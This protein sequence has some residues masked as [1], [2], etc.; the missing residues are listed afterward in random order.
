MPQLTS[1]IWGE[2]KVRERISMRSA[3][4]VFYSEKKI[5]YLGPNVPFQW[6]LLLV[7][8]GME[9]PPLHVLIDHKVG[10]GGKVKAATQEL[11][12]VRTLEAAVRKG[13]KER[14]SH[15]SIYY[16]AIS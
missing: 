14:C 4:H 5:Y 1:S 3:N 2:G 16:M 6:E 15:T 10:L 11:N 12:D 13:L 9:T 8:N 7:Q